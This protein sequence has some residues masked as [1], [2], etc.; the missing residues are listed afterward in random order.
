[1]DR[2]LLLLWA[3]TCK[4]NPESYHPLLCHLIDVARVV[5]ALWDEALGDSLRRSLADALGMDQ[6]SARKWTA[7]WAGAHD[8]GKASP[9]FQVKCEALVPALKEAGF[10]FRPLA[11]APRH[12][13]VTART[14]QGLLSERHEWPALPCDLADQVA[15]TIGGHHGVFPQTA[16]CSQLGSR[17][18]G[19]ERWAEARRELLAALADVVGVGATGAPMCPP[20]GRQAFSMVLAGLTSVADWIGSNTD[21]FPFAAASVDLSAYAAEASVRAK[22]ALGKLGWTG[23]TPPVASR[24]LT[25][26]FPFIGEAR[27]LQQAVIQL[28]DDLDGPALV[29]LEAPMGEGKTEAAM[30]LAD[31]WAVSLKQRGCYFALPTMATS[32]QMFGRVESFLAGRHPADTVNLHLL[33]GHAALS[34]EFEVLRKQGAKLFEAR[35]IHDETRSHDGAPGGVV[36]S[37]WFTH[38]KRGL[39]APFGVGTVDQSLL[40]VLQTKHAFVRL[41][42]LAHKTVIIDEVH[43]YDAYMSVL[44]ERLLEW[45]AALECSVVLL[46]ATLPASRRRALLAAYARGTVRPIRRT[47][48]QPVDGDRSG[49]LSYEGA[50]YPRLSWVRGERGGA[51]SFAATKETHLHLRWQPDDLTALGADLEHALRDGGCAAVVCNTVARAQRVYTALKPHFP[52]PNAGDGFPELD[53]FHARYPFGERDARERRA[54]S[55]FGHPKREGVRRPHRAV[56]VATQVIEQSLDLDFDVMVTD[57]G[58]ADLVLQRAGRLQRHERQRP[59]GFARPELWVIEPATD[60]KGIPAFG[61]DEHVY[62]R[63]ILLRSYL[64]LTGRA[65]VTVP[66]DVEPLIESVYGDEAPAPPSDAWCVALTESRTALDRRR[67]KDEAEAR[68]VLIRPPTHPDNILEDFC[69]QLE[70]DDPGVHPTLQ[71]LTRLGDPT[72]SLVLLWRK[73]EGLALTADA[74]PC[75]DLG[76]APTLDDARAFLRRS[77]SLSHFACVR[78]FSAEKVPESWRRNSLLRHHRVLE[79]DSQGEALAGQYRLR[80]DPE[81]GVVVRK[82]DDG[83]DAS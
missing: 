7:F 82:A 24:S 71:A 51:L 16:T 31:H 26:L 25:E 14:L 41:F 34:A 3:K 66:T 63:H 12:E 47:G 6:E 48:C 40:A 55:R 28:T 64:A 2:D 73:E 35:S 30:Y 29:L 4:D 81:L 23:W 44:L 13:V 60:D 45:L 49:D 54:L 32:N 70:E 42:G 69:Q 74:P 62:D 57:L 5:E 61:A 67:A 36:A 46:S 22:D 21:Y 75:L 43:A 39:L 11:D 83:G 65:T 56:L 27:P 33:H 8:L 20:L 17:A 80:L 78:H 1:M 68:K 79:L 38:R 76:L 59:A 9:G 58:P 15:R 50:A 52:G 77:V 18:L 19:D 37:E 53:L 10:R 72:V